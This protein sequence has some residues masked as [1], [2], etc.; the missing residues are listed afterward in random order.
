MPVFEYAGQKNELLVI[1]SVTG[2]PLDEF[3]PIE[4]G[5]NY[6]YAFSPDRS[7]LAIVTYAQLYLIDL[8][9]WKYRTSD[10]GLH[11]WLS[12]MVYSRD[13]SL[14]ALAAGGP[15]GE[16]VPAGTY[17]IRASAPGRS[18]TERVVILR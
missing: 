18:G 3:A 11:G 13:G 2:N 4:L 10:V 8:P 17:F 6:S 5:Q 15:E 9:S 16:P 1:S 14:L 12:S 7:T